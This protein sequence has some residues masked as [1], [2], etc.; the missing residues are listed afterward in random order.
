MQLSLFMVIKTSVEQMAK[1]SKICLTDIRGHDYY[2]TWISKAYNNFPDH[3]LL[4]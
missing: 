1:T 3:H 2:L 4:F